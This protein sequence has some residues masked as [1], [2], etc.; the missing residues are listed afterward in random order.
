MFITLK[1]KLYNFN[2]L[3]KQEKKIKLLN[4]INRV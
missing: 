4:A 1:N 3:K 2:L